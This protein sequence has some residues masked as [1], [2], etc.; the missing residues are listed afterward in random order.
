MLYYIPHLPAEDPQLPGSAEGMRS[1]ENASGRG[2]RGKLLREKRCQDRLWTLNGETT[3]INQK[4]LLLRGT[5]GFST[6]SGGLIR[7]T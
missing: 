7:F 1:P 2:P 4:N 6:K 5:S 3:Y